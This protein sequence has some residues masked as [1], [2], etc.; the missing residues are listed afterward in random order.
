MPSS[1]RANVYT[2][3]VA[4]LALIA[5]VA[6]SLWLH[7]HSAKGS[8]TPH[9]SPAPVVSLMPSKGQSVAKPFVEPSGKVSPGVPPPLPPF[10]ANPKGS[11]AEE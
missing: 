11:S 1:K 5:L 2:L 7:S 10:A 3:V 9:V 8:T 4:P 6:L